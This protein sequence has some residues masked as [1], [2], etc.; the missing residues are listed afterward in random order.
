[1]KSNDRKTCWSLQDCLD[2]LHHYHHRRHSILSLLFQK[3]LW[4][5]TPYVV[6]GS[7]TIMAAFITHLLPETKGVPLNDTIAA[8]TRAHSKACNVFVCAITTH[9]H[10]LTNERKIS[11]TH[12]FTL[13]RYS[14]AFH[15]IFNQSN[16]LKN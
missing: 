8:L 6:L 5:S 14:A 11:P 13:M 9:T 1:M 15:L 7:A 16:T 10:P 4:V 3:S 2:Y 12:S